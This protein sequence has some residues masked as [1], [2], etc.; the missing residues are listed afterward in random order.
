[1]VDQDVEAG[2]FVFEFTHREHDRGVCV[3]CG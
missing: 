2:F 1:M 3:P